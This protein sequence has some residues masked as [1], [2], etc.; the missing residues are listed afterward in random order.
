MMMKPEPYET[1]ELRDSQWLIS[2][3]ELFILEKGFTQQEVN[4][5]IV[6]NLLGDT[7]EYTLQDTHC[8]HDKELTQ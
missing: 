7:D 2:Q 4:A 5:W 1:R 8:T 6:K 3:L